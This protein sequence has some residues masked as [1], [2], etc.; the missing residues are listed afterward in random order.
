MPHKQERGVTISVPV[1]VHFRAVVVR[2]G[3]RQRYDLS[4]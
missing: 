2:H 3:K 1:S 4:G